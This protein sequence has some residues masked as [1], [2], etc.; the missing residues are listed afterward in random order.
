MTPVASLD[1][2]RAPGVLVLTPRL[3]RDLRI[4]AARSE[5]EVARCLFGYV[6]GDTAYI[7]RAVAPLV[8]RS[9]PTRLSILPC[10]EGVLGVWHNHPVLTRPVQA[11]RG[12]G[13]GSG[14]SATRPRRPVSPAGTG[15]RRPGG[16]PIATPLA[17]CSL[18]G[19]DVRT[20]LRMG[21]PFAV[22][23]VDADTWCWWTLEQVRRAPRTGA[24]AVATQLHVRR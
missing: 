5:S 17:L 14:A 8:L 24:G 2:A 23:G 10:A 19:L 20:T 16:K 4:L 1:D 11:D 18:S 3:E 22:V 15:F 13:K 21:H 7:T 12:E 6:H 9:S